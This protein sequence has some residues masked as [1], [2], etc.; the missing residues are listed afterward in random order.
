MKTLIASGL[1]LFSFFV[2]FSQTNVKIKKDKLLVNDTAICII[3]KKK[4]GLLKPASYEIRSLDEKLIG[5]LESKTLLSPLNNTIYGWYQL[6]FPALSQNIELERPQ[7][8]KFDASGLFPNEGDALAGLILKY[9]LFEQTAFNAPGVEKL[10]V[11]FPKE[12]TT[13][14]TN[15]VAKEKECIAA[16]QMRAKS[17]SLKNITITL[18]KLDS[19]SKEVNVTY[20]IK[21]EERTIGSISAKG[22]VKGFKAEDAEYEY[23]AGI[24]SLDGVTPLNYEIKN[25]EGCTIARYF[26]EEK[27]INTWK[28]GLQHKIGEIKKYKTQDF[29][30]RIDY[31]TAICSLLVKQR[32]M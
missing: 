8:N 28:D 15:L 16:I 26:G 1:C 14:Y 12:L 18:E 23:S 11:D 6:S 19:N 2:S 30:S 29:K 10:K 21:Q 13:D 27:L 32:Y 17:D 5:T 31:L 25:P 4:N 20:S 7:F 9:N 22:S 24:L 3:E